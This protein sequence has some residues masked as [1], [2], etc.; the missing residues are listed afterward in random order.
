MPELHRAIQAPEPAPLNAFIYNRAS[1]DPRRRGRSTADQSA[2]NHAV[3]EDQGWTVAGEFT[4]DDRSASRHA[5]RTRD[6]FEAMATRIRAGECDVL[7]TW[8]SSRANRTMDG[9]VRLRKLIEETGVKWHYGGHTYDMT[10]RRD[11]RDSAHDALQAEDEAEAIRERNLRTTRRNAQR[12]GPHGRIP[13]GYTREYDSKTG[14]LLA[15]VPDPDEAPIAREIFA[16]L[17]AAEAGYSIAQDL[18]GRQIYRRSGEPWDGDSVLRLARGSETYIGKRVHQ[19]K[20]V[21]DAAWDGI[22]EPEVFHAVKRMLAT[23]G[24]R[25]NRDTV[26]KHLLSGIAVCGMEHCGTPL[27]ILKNRGHPTYTCKNG[28]HVACAELRLDA[29]VEEAAVQWL[30]SP[31]SR[32]A[33]RMADSTDRVSHALAEIDRLQAELSEAQQLVAARRLSVA[34]LAAVEAGLL[35]QIEKFRQVAY[36]A[37]VP[38]VVWDLLGAVDADERWNELTI[39]PKR[40]ALRAIVKVRLY[41]GRQGVRRIEPGRVGLRFLGQPEGG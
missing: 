30:Q 11:R 25:S 31:A 29:Y 5:R 34:S 38:A 14:E 4:D 8:E 39:E 36:A 20:T 19:G 6:E 3:C 28:V 37:R 35:P 17:A 12:G 1:R 24:R 10:D 15:Q 7:V 26:V 22:I 13:Y 27:Y 40:T 2:E 41:R 33:F 18:T 16:R 9:Y 32:E 23:P 21:G